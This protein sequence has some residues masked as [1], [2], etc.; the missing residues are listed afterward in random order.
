MARRARRKRGR[1]GGRE[2]HPQFVELLA[3]PAVPR[4]VRELVLE[5]GDARGTWVRLVWRDSGAQGT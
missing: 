1:R 2:A 3:P 5:C 4:P